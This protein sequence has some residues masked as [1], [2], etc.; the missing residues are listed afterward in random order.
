M[1]DH[2]HTMFGH[3]HTQYPW[4]IIKKAWELGLLNGSIPASCGGLELGLLDE[5][6]ICEEIA[7]GC[8]GVMTASTA[9]GLAVCALIANDS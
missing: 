4:D 9:N 5:C 2:T 3:T 7:Y 6:V 8:T 1:L